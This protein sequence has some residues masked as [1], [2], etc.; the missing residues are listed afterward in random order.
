MTTNFAFASYNPYSNTIEDQAGSYVWE[1]RIIN[2]GL[3]VCEAL[4][5]IPGCG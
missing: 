4:V 1:G 5:C 3:T 2:H